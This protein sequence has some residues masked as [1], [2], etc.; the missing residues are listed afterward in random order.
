MLGK[1]M[2][3]NI[4]KNIDAVCGNNH[5]EKILL[6]PTMGKDLFYA[7]PK[8][9]PEN[10]KEGERICGNRISLKEFEAMIQHLT[11]VLEDSDMLM[12]T[13]DLTGHKWKS[14]GVEFCVLKHNKDYI[15]VAVLNK[16]ALGMLKK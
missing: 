16:K 8:Y 9:R 3:K 12:G 10:R 5:D 11:D 4:W 14:R 1:I 15:R 13:V 7:C 2:I 6:E